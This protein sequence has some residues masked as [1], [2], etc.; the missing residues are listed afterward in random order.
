MNCRIVSKV[1]NSI[2]SLMKP[3]KVAQHS[4]WTMQRIN[5]TQLLSANWCWHWQVLREGRTS[6]NIW[7]TSFNISAEEIWAEIS[8]NPGWPDEMDGKARTQDLSTWIS[9]KLNWINKYPTFK[10]MSS[11][12]E[13]YVFNIQAHAWENLP[14]IDFLSF[15]SS[16][17]HKASASS[18]LHFWIF[19]PQWPSSYV[20][21]KFKTQ[22]RKGGGW[23][24]T[25]YFNL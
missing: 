23:R 13:A 25:E 3:Q 10:Q 18:R 24:F 1:I 15:I 22:N 7:K 4:S 8:P 6:Q 14:Y 19:P 16:G 20:V 12:D 9:S 5:C 2:R 11:N 17:L 21:F